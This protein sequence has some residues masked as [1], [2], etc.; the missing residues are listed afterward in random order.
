MLID[1][2]TH[3]FPDAIAE[4]AVTKLAGIG[5]IPYY[6]I[7]TLDDNIKMM[8]RCGVDASVVCSI[9]T[10]LKQQTNVNNFAISLN[11]TCDR[12]Y[13][14]GSIHPDCPVD[15]AEAELR[16]LRDSGI[17]GI[18]V[19]PDYMDAYVDD[20]RFL[21]IFEICDRLGMFVITHAGYDFYSPDNPHSTPERIRRVHDALPSL[22]LVA[23]HVGSNRM[24]REVLDKLVGCE[25]IYFDLS[26]I[27]I[28]PNPLD[29]VKEIV[30]THISDNLLFGSDL[31]WCDPKLELDVIE[32]L[33]LES[34]LM[35]KIRWGNAQKLLGNRKSWMPSV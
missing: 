34:E 9:A 1:F 6:T 10:N 11:A 2:H 19:H 8:D 5:G 33:G 20:D 29:I 35:E 3:C 4:R 22:K 16:R 25:N 24:G 14:L 7:A 26:L 12:I 21:K 15:E 23:A 31:P 18:K 32:S 17:R 13:A 30:T 28:E 27:A